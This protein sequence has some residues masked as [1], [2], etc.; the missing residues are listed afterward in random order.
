[1]SLEEAIRA[2]PCN[3]ATLRLRSRTLGEAL[4]DEVIERIVEI[5]EQQ[6]TVQGASK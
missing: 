2:V 6:K 5:C 4:P 3:G 1:M